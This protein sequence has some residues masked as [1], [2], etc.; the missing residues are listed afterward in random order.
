[1]VSLGTR[2]TFGD[3]ARLAEAYLLDFSGDLYGSTLTLHFVQRLR[4]E[5]RF[6]SISGLIEQIGRDVMHAREVLAGE[7]LCALA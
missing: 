4:D 1:M 2:P 7:Q 3:G 5:L 6:T